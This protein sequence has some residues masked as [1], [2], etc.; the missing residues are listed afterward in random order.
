VAY[1]VDT[2]GEAKRRYVEQLRRHQIAEPG[3]NDRLYQRVMEIAGA[4]PLPY[5]VASSRPMIEAVIQYAGGQGIL[6]R[7]AKIDE[8]FPVKALGLAD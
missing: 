2:F 8:M 4:D 7:R 3:R 6:T 5:G 1:V